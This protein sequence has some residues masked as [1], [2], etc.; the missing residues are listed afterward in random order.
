M[1]RARKNSIRGAELDFPRE[2]RGVLHQTL[3]KRAGGGLK[4]V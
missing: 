4:W 1:V 2:T 3:R